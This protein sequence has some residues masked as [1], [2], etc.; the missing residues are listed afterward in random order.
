MSMIERQQLRLDARDK[1]DR[2]WRV[3]ELIVMMLIVTV[4]S[5]LAQ[6]VVIFVKHYPTGY[7][8]GGGNERTEM[9]SR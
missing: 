6:I 2:R 8:S 5:V 4:V 9:Q 3:V 1:S 7:L